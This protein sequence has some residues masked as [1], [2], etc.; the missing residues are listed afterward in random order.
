MAVELK[1]Q[2]MSLNAIRLKRKMPRICSP[3]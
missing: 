2:L 3:D 1:C